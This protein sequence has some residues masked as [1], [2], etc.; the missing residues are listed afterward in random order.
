[1]PAAAGAFEWPPKDAP[2]T[3]SATLVA[4]ASTYDALLALERRRCVAAV[5]ALLGELSRMQ[6]AA[7]AELLRNL[8]DILQ[9]EDRTE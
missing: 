3:A 8:R 1:M 9:L 5:E 6:P 7:D 2:V 4:D